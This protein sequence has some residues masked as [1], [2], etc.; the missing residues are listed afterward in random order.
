MRKNKKNVIKFTYSNKKVS[1]ISASF[2]STFSSRYL[3]LTFIDLFFG[4]LI[5]MLLEQPLIAV[6]HYIR[7][8]EWNYTINVLGFLIFIG[9]ISL[10]LLSIY[11]LSK[12]LRKLIYDQF[13]YERKYFYKKIISIIFAFL[14]VDLFYE[15]LLYLSYYIASGFSNMQYD[16]TGLVDNVIASM[17][18]LFLLLIYIAIS[19]RIKKRKITKEN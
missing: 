10:I 17:V 3:I 9:I 13:T 19:K 12:K 8:Q 11:I 1:D 4:F 15:P 14:I 7:T 2:D 6:A 5:S 16:I 18:L